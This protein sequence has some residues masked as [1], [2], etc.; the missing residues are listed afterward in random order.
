MEMDNPA[1]RLHRLMQRAQSV[2][3][4]KGADELWAHVFELTKVDTHERFVGVMQRLIWIDDELKLM[5]ETLRT[6]RNYPEAGYTSVRAGIQM[7]IAPQ[8]LVGKAVHV[9]QYLKPEVMA[10][11]FQMSLNL[12]GTEARIDVSELAAFET[13]IDGLVSQV[14]DAIGPV[15]KGVLLRH[16]A[17][18]RRALDAYPIWGVR[19]FTDS[20]RDAFGDIAMLQEASKHGTASPEA[21]SILSSL[22]A[23]W[24]KVITVA[25]TADKAR[26]VVVLGVEVHD[27]FQWISGHL[28]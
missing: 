2:T 24:S 3:D 11:L 15:L 16:I 19:A 17:L 27:G 7:A 8:S 21:Q 18:L 13:L 20:L 1:A 9:K 26:K 14:D 28:N 4:G 23:T 12:T 22:K 6:E 25:T 10:S 5:I